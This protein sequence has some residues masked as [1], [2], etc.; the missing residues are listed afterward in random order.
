MKQINTVINSENKTEIQ[1]EIEIKN[2]EPELFP[3]FLCGE[4]IEIKYSKR[5]KPAEF[6]E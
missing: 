2:K 1:K 3:C 4:F 6:T 5:N